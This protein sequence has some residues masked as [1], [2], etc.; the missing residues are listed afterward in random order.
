MKN[1]ADSGFAFAAKE[2]PKERTLHPQSGWHHEAPWKGARDFLKTEEIS[3]LNDYTIFGNIFGVRKL[4]CAL[5][6]KRL[7][8]SCL[9]AAA[10]GFAFSYAG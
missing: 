3:S 1:K 2:T 10:S 9:N 8:C 6:Y 5:Q 4:A 7:L